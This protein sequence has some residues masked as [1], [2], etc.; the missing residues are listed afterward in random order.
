MAMS[1]KA[2]LEVDSSGEVCSLDSIQRNLKNNGKYIFNE[3]GTGSLRLG[4]LEV[5]YKDGMGVAELTG[6]PAKSA[7]IL[8]R[9]YDLGGPEKIYKN[10][11][12]ITTDVECEKLAKMKDPLAETFDR[13]KEEDCYYRFL[14]FSA[15]WDETVK[16]RIRKRISE[17]HKKLDG[18]GMLFGEL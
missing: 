12:A 13:Q 17:A 9:V 3:L 18:N 15:G 14:R 5:P 16:A 6:C 8:I 1:T 10:G 7:I 4:N 2:S 11:L